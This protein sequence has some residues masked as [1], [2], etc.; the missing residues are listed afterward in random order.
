MKTLKKGDILELNR[1][2][3]LIDSSIG[4]IQV[5]SP[6][7]TIKDTMSLEKGVPLHFCLPKKFFNRNKGISVAEVEFP[8]Y[9]NFFIRQKKTTLICSKEHKEIFMIVLKEALFGPDEFNIKTDYDDSNDPTIPDMKKEMDYFRANLEV[10]SLVDFRVFDE[11]GRV[12]IDGCTIEIDDNHDFYISDDEYGYHRLKVPGEIEYNVQFDLGSVPTEPYKP[13]KFGI[14]CLGPSHG[15]DP[16]D[17]TSGFILW[18]NQRG[19]MIDPPVNTTEWLERSNV[20]PKLI[21]TVILTHT[22]ADHDAGTFQ[23]ILEEGKVTIYTT[24]TIM[25]SWLN[26]YSVLA[27]I[28]KKELCNLFN[29]YPILVGNRVNILGAWFSFS[30]SLHSIPT[31]GFRMT[32]RDKSFV[33]TSDHLNQPVIF[34]T[35]LEKGILN[36]GR[37]EELNAFPWESDIIYHE[38][39]VPPLHTPVEYLNSLS[40]EIQKKTVVYHIAK[41][42]FPP[43][44]DLTLATFGIANSLE[45]EVEEGEFSSA[46][47]ILDTLSRIEY[48]RDFN[49]T[50]LKDLVSVVTKESIPKNT[51]I[52]EK[53][54]KGNKFYVILSGST[55]MLEGEEDNSFGESSTNV[56]RFG[57]YQCFGEVSLLLD[58]PRTA[59]IVAETDVEALT[60]TRSSFLNLIQ[61]TEVEKKLYAIALNRDLDSWDALC[62]T[63]LFNKLTASQ[64]TD[65]E[66]LL[67]RQEVQ[68]GDKLIK[69]DNKLNGLYIF[70]SGN[71]EK[72][73]TNIAFKK[74]DFIGEYKHFELGLD[75]EYDY[76]VKSPGLVFKIGY[77]DFFN[78]IKKN[79][80]VYLRFFEELSR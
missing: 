54:T 17:N 50:Q 60:I 16:E 41:K 39:G 21:D 31:I 71:V 47:E 44:T 79:P 23:K 2:G 36:Q 20:N 7:E 12:D 58:K 48:F 38:A 22:H 13:S 46:F 64:K 4:Y 67:R 8:L 28:D 65:L 73:G 74:G 40:A 35:L 5:G 33:Y 30:Y 57:S 70:H 69:K 62:A 53:G 80:G 75:S 15:F 3:F 66:L 52:I 34:Q 19:I 11:D 43:E 27:Q 6:P 51:K 61:G 55:R 72:V 26:K 29:F 25:E 68:K 76:I 9:F 63:S 77:D 1:G 37:F 32:F 42:D 14:T 49:S 59:D 18:V 45:V 10:N 78:Y 24:K 56:K